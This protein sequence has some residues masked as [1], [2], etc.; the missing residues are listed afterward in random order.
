MRIPA[1]GLVFRGQVRPIVNFAPPIH[2]YAWCLDLMRGWTGEFHES[3]AGHSLIE[4]PKF[5]AVQAGH[6]Q[7]S[8]CLSLSL[9]VSLG[10]LCARARRTRACM[11]ASVSQAFQCEVAMKIVSRGVAWV[12]DCRLAIFFATATFRV[13]LMLTGKR[14]VYPC[15]ARTRQPKVADPSCKR[16]RFVAIHVAQQTLST[17]T[18]RSCNVPSSR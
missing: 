11:C 1:K 5:S 10:C 12:A 9:S 6:G 8:L 18:I 14:G 17:R 4:S 7:G 16:A 13:R 15:V 3:A 2:A